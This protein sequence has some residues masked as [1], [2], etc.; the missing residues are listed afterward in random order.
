V[1]GSAPGP[2]SRR[3]RTMPDVV[4]IPADVKA[5][6]IVTATRPPCGRDRAAVVTI[7]ILQIVREALRGWLYRRDV[8]LSD[9]R[10][11]IEALLRDEFAGVQQQ[12]IADRSLPD[13]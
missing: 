5:A 11:S 10:T 12:A 2:G 4:A 9:V 7:A 6:H 3:G 13:A 1:E 8:D